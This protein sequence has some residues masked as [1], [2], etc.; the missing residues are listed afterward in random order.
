MTSWRTS[1]STQSSFDLLAA[2]SWRI[3]G[4][5]WGVWGVWNHEG[6]LALAQQYT[7][8]TLES[9][10]FVLKQQGWMRSQAK[11]AD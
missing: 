6:L 10:Q 4:G 11:S 8:D 2:L 7:M 5:A 9:F 3:E 1:S